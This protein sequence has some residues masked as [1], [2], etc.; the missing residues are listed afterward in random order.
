MHQAG[1]FGRIQDVQGFFKKYYGPNNCTL[2]IAGDI[3]VAETKALVEKYFGPIKPS[4]PISRKEKWIPELTR[5]VRLQMEDR[6]PLP[7]LDMVWHAPG[8]FQKGEADLD[9]LARV[10]ASGKNSRLYKKLVYELGVAQSVRAYVDDRELGID[11]A[12]RAQA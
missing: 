10:L 8:Y 9:V 11:T 5:E 12:I 6:A 3:D 7:R 2:S 1:F 4:P